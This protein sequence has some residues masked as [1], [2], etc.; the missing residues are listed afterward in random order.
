MTCEI[1]GDDELSGTD[2]FNKWTGG[3][4]MPWYSASIQPGTECAD[5]INNIPV[6]TVRY[7]WEICNED[8]EYSIYLNSTSTHFKVGNAPISVPD[9]D[10]PMAPKTC[11][12][13]TFETLIDLCDVN[14]ANS[15]RM[16]PMRVQMEGRLE[17]PD[18]AEDEFCHCKC[19]IDC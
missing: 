16:T 17:R 10:I 1:V 7:T 14:P 15:R 9:I 11:T 8:P 6:V 5:S 18:M 19:E 3:E 13:Q 4:E 12:T 2:C